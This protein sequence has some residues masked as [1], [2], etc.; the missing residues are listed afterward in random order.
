MISR[1]RFLNIVAAAAAAVPFTERS[2][3]AMLFVKKRKKSPPRR[4]ENVFTVEGKALVGVAGGARGDAVEGK[5]AE[6]VS[7]IGGFAK[8]GIKGKT[9]LVKPNVVNGEQSPTTTS[10]GVVASVVR[11]LYGEGAAK[12]YVGDMSA[13]VT[14]STKRNMKRSGITGAAEAEGAEVVVFEDHR[15]DEVALPGNSIVKTAYVTEWLYNV[16]LVVNLPVI[17]THKSASYSICLKNFIGCTH[18][19]QRPYIIDSSRWEEI[20]A[21]FNAAYV[22]DLNIVDGT[23]SMVEG[24][25]WRGTTRDT[26]VIIASGDRVAAD[27]VGL[28]VIK[29]FGLWDMVTAKDV[30]DQRQIRTAL[31]IG[32]G[33]PRERIRLVT[34][35]GDGEFKALMERVRGETGLYGSE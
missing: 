32:A 24:G 30:W 8:L 6:A 2:A 12:V 31:E 4:A 29:S 22:P 33:S 9:V 14:L 26:G 19:K 3:R 23:V 18:L 13:L 11:L 10:P 25:P 15:W 28:G 35:G 34:G 7:L 5:V 17:K 16:D 27:A 20:V 1:R 21:E